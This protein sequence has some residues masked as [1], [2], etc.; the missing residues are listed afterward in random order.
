V[1]TF[2][3][4]SGNTAATAS[5]FVEYRLI[6]FTG[7]VPSN[8]NF[9]DPSAIAV[10][11]L[12]V[13]EDVPANDQIF[14][15]QSFSGHP[16]PPGRYVVMRKLDSTNVYAESNESDNIVVL[17]SARAVSNGTVIVDGSAG[18][19]TII[20]TVSSTEFDGADFFHWDLSINGVAEE[21]LHDTDF[22]TGF[23]IR[24]GDGD[25]TVIIQA[26]QESLPEAPWLKYVVDGGGGN[27]R[28]AGSDAA[29]TLIGGWGKDV[30]DGNG[31]NDKLAGG[32]GADRLYGYNGNDYLNGGSSG[33]RLEG[34]AGNDTLA[35]ESGA[36]RFFTLDGEPDVLFGGTNRDSVQGDA[37]DLLASVEQ[38]I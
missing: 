5:F 1:A 24:A 36:D 14:L 26:G 34:G 22:I 29:E 30:L 3:I 8:P 10:A 13:H 35:G 17:G 33:D 2:V 15:R 11:S 6:P 38:Q 21:T 7:A 23:D 9:D 32:A 12:Q 16:V 37:A 27:D 28:I 20:L 19:D 25:D 4:N 18:P 31:G